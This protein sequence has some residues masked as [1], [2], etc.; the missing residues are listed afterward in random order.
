MDPIEFQILDWNYYNYEND[1]GGKDYHI[2]LF[3]R[4]R[5]DKS[6]HV[7]V[8]GFRPYFYVKLEKTWRQNTMTTILNKIREKIYPRENMDGLISYKIVEKYD[9]YGF[10]NY[11]KYEFM[12]LEF[13][14]YDSMISYNN[15]FKKKLDL[16]SV[17]YK[18][19]K[20][21]VYESNIEP[22]IRCMHTQ[23]LD[24]VG[25]VRIEKYKNLPET[26]DIMSCCNIN[27]HTKY[28]NLIKIDDRTISPF[29]IAGFDI[30]CMS[31]DGSFPQPKRDGDQIIQIGTTFSR[32]GDSECYRKVI[33][34]LKSC[35]PI[36]GVEV[37]SFENEVQLMRA[38][39][40][41][42]E[43]ED[44]DIITG[45]N[46]L[47]FD[48]NYMKKR[49]K[50]LGIFDTFSKLSRIKEEITVFKKTKL[51]SSALGD[52]LLKYY[53][54]TGRVIIDLMKVIQR[55]HKLASY[56]L[57]YVSSYFI[58]EMVLKLEPNPDKK[59]TMIITKGTY[60]IKLDQYITIF[61]NDG[62]TENKHMDGKKFKVKQIE[63]DKLLVD[64]LIDL[65]VM[66]YGYKVFWCQAKDDVGP[67]DIFKF[68]LEGPAERAIIAKYCV[69][70]CELC[71]KLVAKLQI[72][73]NNIGMANVCN[74]PFSYI[75]MR[76]QGVKIFSLVSKE[77]RILNHLIPVLKKKQKKEKEEDKEEGDNRYTNIVENYD[78]RM[79]NQLVEKLNNKHRESNEENDDDD[80]EDENGYEGAIVFEPRPGV[81][82]EPIPVLDYNSLYPSSMIQ[83]NLSH[84]C[85]INT[86]S[87]DKEFGYLKEYKYHE[88]T[89]NT[90]MNVKE[91]IKEN[92]QVDMFNYI[93]NIF[94]PRSL[95]QYEQIIENKYKITIEYRKKEKEE[96]I[97]K[98][99]TLRN[100][101]NTIIKN[102]AKYIKD[103]M[104]ILSDNLPRI[105]RN[106]TK[107]EIEMIH[108]IENSKYKFFTKIYN[109]RRLWIE[110]DYT[111]DNAKIIIYTICKFAEKEDGTKGIIPQI[112]QKLLDARKHFK[113]LMD[114]EKDSFKKTV[115][116]G[117]Q[118]AY[119]VTA[120]SLYGQTGAPTSS[121]YMKEIAASTTATGREMLQFSKH[122]IEKIYG[123]MINMALT[124]NKAYKEFVNNKFDKFPHMV[125]ETI[126]GKEIEFMVHLED[127]VKLPEKKFIDFKKRWTNKEEYFEYFS[128]I[129]ND[130]FKGYSLDP[131]IIY[132]DTDSVFF[133]PRI[134]EISSG[135]IINDKKSLELA[136]QLGIWASE[137]IC[138]LLPD[139]QKQAYEK[140][141]YPFAI[142]SKKRYIGNLYE[143]DPNK[144]Y[145]KSMGIVLKRRD[146]APIVKIVYGGIIETII[147]K[148]DAK[149]AVEYTRN[150]LRR[151]LGAKYPIDK[152]IITKT[153]K[154]TYK[155]RTRI[156][157]A[158]LADRMGLRDAGNKPM[159]NDRI[160]YVY[161]ETKNDV[162]LQGDRVE[163]PDYVI[164]RKLR[165]DYLFYITNQIMKPCIQFLDLVVEDAEEIFRDYI[166]REENRRDGIQP[167]TAFIENNIISDEE[168]NDFKIDED[169]MKLVKKEIKKT[170][171]K[172]KPIV[173]KQIKKQEV[174]EDSDDDIFKL[175]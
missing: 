77:C 85:N 52:N 113:N 45:Y 97:V 120:N 12:K 139:P 87:R 54:M 56:K 153:L 43:E 15:A 107:K 55:D 146:N 103:I 136:I 145:Q 162:K 50:K 167:I 6:I 140:V 104:T 96:L 125:K 129:M 51:A 135:K 163:H 3:G 31:E 34:T 13:S 39:T 14:S 4:T 27:I 137:M 40:K 71:N 82:Y 48:F 115:L 171:S 76:G 124:D 23:D 151:I 166:I 9:F 133:N 154:E 118:L 7:D 143:T 47:G 19:I 33:F 8:T 108:D 102:N 62:I 42:L 26:S 95:I 148:K 17:S 121:I 68:Q 78:S 94:I 61:Y 114:D 134:K 90:V 117:L 147:N 63:K 41:L 84:E 128:K 165:I 32:F 152:F 158:V 126:N 160:P 28:T 36:E 38:W 119:K 127:N 101:L 18:P 131:I 86:E 53:D 144:Y 169:E 66:T 65:E 24:S 57:D 100:F 172:K 2:R 59:E 170:S 75:F 123:P 73:P 91:I 106:L 49:S 157:H 159:P 37:K 60:G 79:I 109:K 161:I 116:D 58:R 155:D 81:Y 110:L 168:D 1:E 164:K 11:T 46:I 122:F 70:D 93:I 83:R 20:F 80:N 35:N 149:G 92:E 173:K 156:V 30:E 21:Q 105:V 69:M 44:P 72:I 99:R 88:I 98:D 130:L 89:F 150:I 175:I 67:Q 112:L 142:L 29:K 64:G 138:K 141:L 10:S 174:Y 111:E 5:D 74:V 16:K 22:H 132:G 25:W